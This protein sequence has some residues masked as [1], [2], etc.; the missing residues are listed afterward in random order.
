MTTPRAGREE[1][2]REIMQFVYGMEPK[3]RLRVTL[4]IMDAF[5]AE[6]LAGAEAMR[7][8]A[9]EDTKK[10][11]DT[12]FAWMSK[13]PLHSDDRKEKSL[14]AGELYDT[15]ERIRAIP[16]ESLVPPAEGGKGGSFNG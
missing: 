12:L 1:R 10:R 16:V 11:A 8:K 3:D 15:V 5:D 9:A 4:K 7:E 2:A 13:L 6:F 14:R